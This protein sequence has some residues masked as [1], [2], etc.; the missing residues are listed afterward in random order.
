M[1]RKGSG[2][3]CVSYRISRGAGS[4]KRWWGSTPGALEEPKANSKS[5]RLVT[6]DLSWHGKYSVSSR[7]DATR[8]AWVQGNA[9]LTHSHCPG[10]YTIYTITISRFASSAVCINCHYISAPQSS[11]CGRHR[12]QYH[13]S[14]QQR[15]YQVPSNLSE[16]VASH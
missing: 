13:Q 15:A 8:A 10:A 6:G 7:D 12:L 3:L 2:K 16:E 4:R 14:W 9:H 5:R 11:P 1:K